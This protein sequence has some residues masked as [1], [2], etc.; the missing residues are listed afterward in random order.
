M[1]HT[2]D[3]ADSNAA[4]MTDHPEGHCL[5]AYC[6]RCRNVIDAV[7]PKCKSNVEPGGSATV[8]GPGLSCLTPADFYR[9]LL[10]LLQ[11][12][13]NSK[14]TMVCYLIATGDAYADG[15]TMAEVAKAWGVT[16]AAVSKHCRIICNYLGIPP[17]QY[18]RKEET[19][20]KYRESNRR[21]TSQKGKA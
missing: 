11:G 7:C 1:S 3:P 18:M 5:E 21:P 10:T 15:V 13:R 12:Q 2:Q 6:P 8:D 14:F 9:R 16:R 20:A 19:A 17:S 4:S